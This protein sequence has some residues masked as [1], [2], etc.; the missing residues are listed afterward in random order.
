MM[1][2]FHEQQRELM[3]AVMRSPNPKTDSK[4]LSVPY[5]SDERQRVGDVTISMESMQFCYG[6]LR[7]KKSIAHSSCGADTF[8]SQHT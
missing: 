3:E 1:M 2:E 5:E 8:K 7:I 6:I 4:H